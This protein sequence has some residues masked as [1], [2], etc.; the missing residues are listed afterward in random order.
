[1]VKKPVSLKYL[2]PFSDEV[3]YSVSAVVAQ[4]QISSATSGVLSLT[5]TG[6]IGHI[7]EI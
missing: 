1:M 4:L 6:Q 2:I 5:G 3:S 7:Y